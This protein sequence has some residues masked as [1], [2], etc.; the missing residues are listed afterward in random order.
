MHATRC[1]IP[2]TE[3]DCVQEKINTTDFIQEVK[4]HNILLIL[5]VPKLVKDHLPDNWPSTKCC[6]CHS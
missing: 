2:T 4:Q 1:Q 5:A 3:N 6:C